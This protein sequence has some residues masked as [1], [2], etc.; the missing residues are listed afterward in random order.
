MN[1]FR[2]MAK[3]L[4]TAAL[5]RERW[6]VHGPRR[7]PDGRKTFALTFDDGPHPEWTPQV[8]DALQRW[9]QTATFFVIGF[10]VLRYP[11]IVERIVK[12][13]H[14]LGNHTYTHSEPG[15]T[16]SEQFLEEVKHTRDLLV[17][18]TGR[19]PRCVRPPKGELTWPKLRG[20]WKARQTVVLWSVDPRDYRMRDAAEVERFCA[21]YEPQQGDIILMHDHHPAAVELLATWGR[22]GLFER[23]SSVS[24]ESWLQPSLPLA[25]T[26]HSPAQWFADEA[27]LGWAADQRLLVTDGSSSTVPEDSRCRV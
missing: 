12:E 17:C 6:L 16:S 18:R 23:W 9:G 3:A 5:P 1:Y 8:L 2:Q 7:S 13:G 10:K 20:L 26:R 19:L 27:H 14:C 4:L 21:R 25:A 22:R 24:V 11:Q 15:A